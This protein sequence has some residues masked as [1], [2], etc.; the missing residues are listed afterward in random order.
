MI[1]KI[2][3][4]SWEYTCDCGKKSFFFI[5]DKPMIN[6][7]NLKED[8]SNY[9]IDELVDIREIVRKNKD[10]KLSDKIRDYLDSKLVFIFDTPNGQEIYYYPSNSNITRNKLIESIN[11]KSR[12]EKN[13]NAWLYS[14]NESITKKDEKA[15]RNSNMV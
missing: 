5:A 10:W 9:L 11:T 13:F 12:A 15:K 14:V 2:F 1:K 6:I 7:N 3:T 4:K 8:L